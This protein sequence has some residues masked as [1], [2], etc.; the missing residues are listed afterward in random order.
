MNFVFF[1]PHFPENGADFCR[2]LKKAGAT[3]LGIGDAHYDALPAVLKQSLDEY[4]RISD[5][6]E[7]EQTFRAIGHFI[8][9]WGRIDRFESLNEHWLELEAGIRTDFNIFGT[10]LDYVQNLKRKSRMRA[11]FRKSGV[12]II[13]QRKCSDRA[14]ALTFIRRVGY[15]VV[16]KP[17]SG[18]GASMT[19]KISNQR[20]LNDF[21]ASKPADVAFVMEQFIDGLVVTYDGLANRDGEVVLAST[22]HYDQSVMDVV[23]TDSHMSYV[24]MPTIDPRIE[25][26]G[27]KILKAFDVR[28]RF[29]HI[30][31][32]QTRR[33]KRIIAL[34][35]NMRP[36]GAWITDAINY[37]YDVDVYQLWAD[38]VVKDAAAERAKGKY[39]TA[40]AS[41]KD[42][43]R[44]R[45]D[46]QAVLAAHGDV[47]IRH[48]PIEKIFSKAMGNFA[49][50]MRSKNL[51]DLREAVRYI[52]A[53]APAESAIVHADKLPQDAQP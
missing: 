36:P 4:Y 37:S 43:I 38:M 33:D 24:C 39:F 28:E 23:N 30:E 34:E 20:E 18:S 50:Q 31:L 22:T 13:P 3:L 35:V 8:H 19:Y 32:F 42:H 26:A 25:D 7:Y 45:H 44:Y 48:Q 49:Y 46:H 16:V 1:S 51:A 47:I 53:E 40:Y 5:M 21:L 27:R 2:G 12:D 17:D 6:E 14:G 11:F 10:K 29:F 9:K 15:P 52:H 41:R